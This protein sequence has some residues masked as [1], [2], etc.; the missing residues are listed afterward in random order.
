MSPAPRSPAAGA[1]GG[2]ARGMMMIDT[3]VSCAV[4][5]SALSA[6]A[7]LS[8]LPSSSGAWLRLGPLQA[9]RLEGAHAC[10]RRVRVRCQGA[11]GLRRWFPG[12]CSCL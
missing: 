9:P 8:R 2:Y 7:A 11:G 12:L 1:G 10:L 5:P 6:A 3:Q 4:R